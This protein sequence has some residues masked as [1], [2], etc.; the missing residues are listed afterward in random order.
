MVAFGT[1]NAAAGARSKALLNGGN[2][3]ANALEDGFGFAVHFYKSLT[4]VY[5]L[6]WRLGRSFSFRENSAA[7]IVEK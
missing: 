4:T 6:V 5:P 3:A 1:V 2:F 7:S